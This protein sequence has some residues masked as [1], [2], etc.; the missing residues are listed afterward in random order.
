LLT[1]Q[2][3]DL[4]GRST[5]VQV[6]SDPGIEIEETAV[7][8]AVPAVPELGFDFSKYGT[9]GWLI[10]F[11]VLGLGIAFFVIAREELHRPPT[12]SGVRDA[13]SRVGDAVR[14]TGKSFGH[15]GDKRN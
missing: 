7:A 13:A 6:E 14:D 3:A 11:L 12:A 8:A 15:D 4:E 2:L 5:E 1:R 9:L 10:P